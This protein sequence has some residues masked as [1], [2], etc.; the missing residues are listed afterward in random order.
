MP[1]GRK[2]ASSHPRGVA[3]FPTPAVPPRM[4]GTIPKTPPR[5][6]TARCGSSSRERPRGGS[7]VPAQDASAL[8]KEIDELRGQ[9]AELRDALA[10]ARDEAAT[11]RGQR[12]RLQA[13]IAHLR[14]SLKRAD[15]NVR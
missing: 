9:A 14:E 2:P 3:G 1:P 4:L 8:Q 11:V 12:D 6:G 13:E 5:D 7:T 15:D 10:L